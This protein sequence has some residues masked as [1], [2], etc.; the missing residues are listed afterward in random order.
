MIGRK[1]AGRKLR[2]AFSAFEEKH[3]AYLRFFGY[4]RLRVR[5]VVVFIAKLDVSFPRSLRMKRD[6]AAAYLSGKFPGT[7]MKKLATGLQKAII[8]GFSRVI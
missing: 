4:L 2:E 1:R 5:S 8:L 7:C 3:L 6:G